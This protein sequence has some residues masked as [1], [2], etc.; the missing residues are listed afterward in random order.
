MSGSVSTT[1]RLI[2]A[3]PRMPPITR[4]TTSIFR[5]VLELIWLY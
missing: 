5:C 2:V 4:N 1:E 3:D